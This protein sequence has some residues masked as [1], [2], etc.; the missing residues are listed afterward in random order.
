MQNRL[1]LQS[2][3]CE[4][5]YTFFICKQSTSLQFTLIPNLEAV[6]PR[7]QHSN[8]PRPTAGKQKKHRMC[9]CL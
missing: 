5:D 6:S 2:T 4:I 3:M 7:L 9:F 8:A 1:I